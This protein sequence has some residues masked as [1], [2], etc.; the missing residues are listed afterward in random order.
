[1]LLGGTG[2]EQDLRVQDVSLGVTG[3]PYSHAATWAIT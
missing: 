3:L 2:G 1:M